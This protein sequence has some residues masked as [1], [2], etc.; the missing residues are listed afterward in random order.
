MQQDLG[1]RYVAAFNARH[2]RHGTLWDGRFH[3]AAIQPGP[4]EL[5]A[6][7]F[8]EQPGAGEPATCSAPH[9]L[10]QRIDPWLDD[11][12]AYWA[13]G[14]TPFERQTAWR[15]R[16]EHGLGIAEIAAVERALRSGI[17]LA[18][19]S[20]LRDLQPMTRLPLFPRARGRPRRVSGALAPDRAGA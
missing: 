9:H 16:L 10:G 4:R 6:L 20:W 19:P 13:L 18:D 2:R 17:P 14:N 11:P 1:R 3:S 5:V 7:L 15:Q 12:P 8:I